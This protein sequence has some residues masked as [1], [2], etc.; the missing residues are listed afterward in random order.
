MKNTAKSP[1]RVIEAPHPSL[2]GHVGFQIVDAAGVVVAEAFS[3]PY[4][5]HVN[6]EVVTLAAAAPK[7][8]G[9]LRDIMALPGAAADVAR[10]G[11][12]DRIERI[13]AAA[14]DRS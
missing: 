7:M 12:A 6:R 9:A 13:M 10:A 1:W 2:P 14:A 8:L 4:P 5:V 3:R 11:Y